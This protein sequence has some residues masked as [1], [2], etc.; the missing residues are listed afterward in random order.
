MRHQVRR[1]NLWVQEQASSV[2]E[3]LIFDC[4]WW[5]YIFTKEK[6]KHED[7]RFELFINDI[8]T[9]TRIICG[10]HYPWCFFIG[11]RRKGL[12]LGMEASRINAGV[13][14]LLYHTAPHRAFDL[15][16]MGIS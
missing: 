10:V 14:S 11:A 6:E 3:L 16:F 9:T 12:S 13:G 4:L 2:I 7:N 1:H 8:K 5:P 15:I